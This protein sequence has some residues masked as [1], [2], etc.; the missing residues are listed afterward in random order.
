MIEFF[1][2]S[3]MNLQHILHKT[4]LLPH[5]STHHFVKNCAEAIIALTLIDSA[6][7]MSLVMR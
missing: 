1:L 2:H 4:G 5:N 7:V 3:T 6:R